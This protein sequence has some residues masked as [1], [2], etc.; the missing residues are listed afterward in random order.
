MSK[1]LKPSMSRS[2][3]FYCNTVCNALKT[4]LADL[5]A[6]MH[7]HNVTSIITLSTGFVTWWARDANMVLIPKRH[8]PKSASEQWRTITLG[9]PA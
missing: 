4:F 8:V 6:V 2:I 5:S 7:K 1:D 3:K 9:P